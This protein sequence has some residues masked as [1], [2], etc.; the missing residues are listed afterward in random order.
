MKK[1]LFTVFSLFC[2]IVLAFAQLPQGFTEYQLDNGL[3]VLLWEDHDQPDVFGITVT[4]AGSIDEPETATGLAHYLEHMLFK[5]TDRIGALDWEKEK[6]HYEHIIALYDTLAMTAD[7]KEREAIQLKINEQSRISAQFNATD[8]FS[9][10]I[11][12]IGG[13]DLNAATSYDM[14]YYHNRF[15]S[16]QMERWLTLYADRLTNPVF[17]GF[18]AELENVFEEYNMYSDDNAQHV[19]SFINAELYKGSAYARDI[20]GFPEDLKN[21]KLRQLIDFYK[22]W[23]VPNNM[24]LILVGNFSSDEAKPLIEKTFGRM[25]AKP[26]PSRKHFTPT[27]FTSDERFSAK[28]G[29]FPELCVAYDGVK[30]GADDELALDFACNLLS[31]SMGIGLLDEM[32]LDN[33]LM[34]AVASNNGAREMGRIE[35]IAI[36]YMDME[37]QSYR[38]L[39]ETEKLVMA[40]VNQLVQGNVSDD[41][42]EAVKLNLQDFSHCF[43]SY[44]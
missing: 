29:Y 33:R 6:P 41:L 39:K 38:S 15:P 23:Y 18:Q 30:V 32:I 2:G 21:P 22:T 9:N 27:V 20:I 8:E 16:Y 24:A 26:L 37:S 12:S 43:L 10:L 7:P 17:R 35:V 34:Y 13:E 42:F 40:A 31:N 3:T 19:Q 28:L 1:I 44:Y 4:R 25:I 14:T 11:Q 36:P 5:G